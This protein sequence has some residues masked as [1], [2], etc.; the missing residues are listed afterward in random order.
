MVIKGFSKLTALDFPKRVA[1]T[2]FTGG[3]NMRCPFCHNASLVE[4]RADTISADEIFDF[5]KKRKGLLDGVAITGGEPLLQPGIKDFIKEIKDMGY[6]VKLDTNG[7][8][9]DTL[10]DIVSSGLCDY[11]AMDIKNSPELYAKTC[12]TDNINIKDII[13]SKDFLLMGDVEYEF[14]TTVVAEYHTVESIRQAAAFIAGANNYYL[15]AFKDSGDLL[16]SGLSG[17]E[18]PVMEDMCTAALKYVKNCHIRGV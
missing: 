6:A 8:F 5:L 13:K 1:C 3:C 12:G 17:L 4:N 2:V 16:V 7:S 10:I 14:R 15:Q 11:V 9:P 18:K